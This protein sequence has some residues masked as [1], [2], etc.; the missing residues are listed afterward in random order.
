MLKGCLGADRGLRSVTVVDEAVR[1]RSQFLLYSLSFS[2]AKVSHCKYPYRASCEADQDYVNH[3][4][5][6][7]EFRVGEMMELEVRS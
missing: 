6:V 7:P 1:K 4:N 2:F 3:R 5:Q